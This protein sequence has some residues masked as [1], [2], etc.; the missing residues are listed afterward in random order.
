M[1]AAASQFVRK[2]TC[3]SKPNPAIAE[4]MSAAALEIADVTE[5]LIARLPARR[6]PP[7]TMPP[8]RRPEVRER[9]RAWRAAR[10]DGVLANREV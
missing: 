6:K 9:L 5:Q 1:G 10:T 2:V 4:A 8:L 3:I 7:K